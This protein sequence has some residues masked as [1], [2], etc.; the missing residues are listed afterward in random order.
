M[1]I[2]I[3]VSIDPNIYPYMLFAMDK[4]ASHWEYSSKSKGQHL[5]TEKSVSTKFMYFCF[6]K[7]LIFEGAEYPSQA[8]VSVCKSQRLISTRLD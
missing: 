4:Y 1:S 5:W 7:L 8:L 6:Q 3:N 2:S